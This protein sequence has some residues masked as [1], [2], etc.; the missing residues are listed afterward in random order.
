M[1]GSA[2]LYAARG[3]KAK[4]IVFTSAILLMW[5]GETITAADAAAAGWLLLLSSS[6]ALISLNKAETDTILFF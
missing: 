2:H 4:S 6:R 5:N 1:M 3:S